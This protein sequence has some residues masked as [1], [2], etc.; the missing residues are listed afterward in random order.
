MKAYVQLWGTS[1]G[2]TRLVELGD[3]PWEELH[4]WRGQLVTE[5][6][7]SDLQY[8]IVTVLSPGGEC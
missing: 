4:E 1:D 7:F 6:E 8:F 2:E 3:P 5:R